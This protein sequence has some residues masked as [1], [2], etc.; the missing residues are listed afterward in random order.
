VRHC[1]IGCFG[2]PALR[3]VVKSL[4]KRCCIPTGARLEGT[5]LESEG[6][7][8]EMGFPTVDQGFQAFKA[9]FIMTFK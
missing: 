9:L 3:A 8:A 1:A 2:I 7:R 5:K 4:S 6:P